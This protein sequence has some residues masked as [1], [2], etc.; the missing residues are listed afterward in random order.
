[1]DKV[2]IDQD[3]YVEKPRNNELFSNISIVTLEQV[4]QVTNP[5]IAEV[6]LAIVDYLKTNIETGKVQL[7]EL[8]VEYAQRVEVF[9]DSI[10]NPKARSEAQI[11]A[12]INKAIIFQLAGNVT[13]WLEELDSAE[14]YASNEGFTTVAVAL[15]TEIKNNVEL[16]DLS[17]EKILLKL[18]GIVSDANREFLK[19]SIEEGDDLEDVIN[20]AYGMILDEGE[21]PDEVLARLGIIE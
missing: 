14:V 21:D 10:E 4:T 7:R 5:E 9:V 13:R 12:I 18:R 1:M 8:W 6:S 19:D 3:S 20:H 17:S 2:S 16:L 11:A 15:D